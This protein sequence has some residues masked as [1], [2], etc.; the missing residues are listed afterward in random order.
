MLVKLTQSGRPSLYGS[1][2]LVLFWKCV[3]MSN[4]SSLTGVVG[5]LYIADQQYARCKY[6]GTAGQKW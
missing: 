1:I 3:L 5:A 4:L 6:A 2:N